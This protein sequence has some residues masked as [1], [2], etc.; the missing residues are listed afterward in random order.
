[1]DYYLIDIITR[2][3]EAFMFGFIIYGL[4]EFPAWLREQFSNENTEEIEEER[5]KAA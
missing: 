3:V 2:F 4:W 5:I 1:M